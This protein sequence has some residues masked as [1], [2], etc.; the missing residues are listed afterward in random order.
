MLLTSALA[1][2]ALKFAGVAY[3]LYIAWATWRDKTAF[4]IDGTPSARS[5]TS[6]MAKA[7]LL[8]ILNPKLTIFFLAFLPQFVAP[9]ASL[10]LMQLLM[11]SGIF[12][13]MTFA[14][15]VVYG[16]LAH[17]F[18]KTVTESPRVQSWLRRSF[19]AAFAGLGANLSLSDR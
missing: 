19:A 18:R 13:A 10:P 12:M 2:Q 8:N 4:V 16:F 7:F 17:A 5:A 3:L 14:V 15:F 1:F 9:N 11:L 6:L